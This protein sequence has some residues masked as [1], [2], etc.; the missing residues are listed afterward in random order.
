M[1]VVRRLF[2]A[3]LAVLVVM[4]ASRASISGRPVA[5]S[6]VGWPPSASMLIAEV[7]TGGTASAS[8][9]YVELTNRSGADVDVAGLELVYATSSGATVTRK[10]SW[11]QPTM[12]GP[13]RHL[14]VANGTGRY[15]SVAD[16]VYSG[17]LAATGGAVVLRPIGGAPL[18]ALAWGDATN[19]FVEGTTA[20]APP[21]GS[22]IERLPGGANGNL[23]DTNDNAADVVTTANPV[24]Q[25]LSDGPSTTPPP[26]PT[27]AAT[28]TPVATATQQPTP[29]PI[30]TI[31]PLPTSLP[32]PTVT[33]VPTSIPTATPVPTSIP[34]ATPASTPPPTPQPT[35]TATP[36]PT[37]VEIGDARA[38]PD[39]SA[40]TVEGVLTTGLGS[41]EGGHTGYL[42]DS[43]SGIALYTGDPVVEVV[44]AG[45]VVRATGTVDDRF[46]QRTLRVDLDSVVVLGTAPLPDP[47]RIATGTA[48]ESR[49]DQRVSASGRVTASPDAVSDGI[50]VS[51]DDGTG[52]LRVIVTT[53]AVGDRAI[54]TG[55]EVEVHGPLGQRD[56]TGSGATGY[57][58]VVALAPDLVIAGPTPTSTPSP[59]STPAPTAT[60]APS[61]TAVATP[62]PV[63]TP[64]PSATP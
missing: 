20:P 24:A 52:S 21:A 61:A 32:T 12:V 3:V 13:G 62:T 15:A 1:R 18:D 22:S 45:S 43:S 27:P 48:D 54:A 39:G 23:V 31:T 34:T 30:A 14:L 49:E 35:P 8:D 28:P 55:D 6:A 19:A 17:G 64:R 56:S 58:V 38:L 53:E 41:L 59:T 57:R 10:A 33:P 26:T 44:A 46:A 5:A 51:I 4:L 60:P 42:Q 37:P 40:V 63:A 9:E 7:V 2:A 25:N 47:V 29:T 36:A 11:S 50:A 16:A